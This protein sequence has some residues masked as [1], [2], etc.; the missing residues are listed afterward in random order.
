VSAMVPMGSVASERQRLG[1]VVSI[2][3]AT[4]ALRLNR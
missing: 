1:L 3:L 4:G 2:A